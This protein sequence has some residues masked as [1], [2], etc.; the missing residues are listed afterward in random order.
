MTTLAPPPAQAPV[1]EPGISPAGRAWHRWRFWLVLALAVFVGGTAIALIGSP[2]TTSDYLDPGNPGAAGARAVATIAA[3]RGVHLVRVTTVAAAAGAAAGGQATLV[4]TSPWL[5]TTG[6]LTALSR[7]PGDRLLIEPD[8][9]S[10]T[11]LAPGVTEVG[12]APV[13][14]LDPGCGLPAATLAGSADLGGTLL[15]ASVPGAQQCYWSAGHPS[16]VRYTS[17]GRTITVLGSGAPLRNSDLASLGNAALAL[18]LLGGRP[19]IVWLVP[20][21]PP[22]AASGQKSLL[23]LI[24]LPAYLVALQLAIAAVLCALWRTRRLGPLVAERLPAVVR[25]T[26]TVEGHGQ[27]YRSRRSRDRAAAALRDAARGRL[28]PR[29]GLPDNGAPGALVTALAGQTSSTPEQVAAILFG[30]VPQDDAALVRLADELDS[31]ENA[32]GRLS[33][34]AS[35]VGRPS[36]E[37]RKVHTQ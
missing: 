19:E 17:G 3:Q 29:L 6:E 28:A 14:P 26:E 18:N 23:S 32:V 2:S 33:G 8:P 11:A 37:A 10:L 4:V 25:A 5:L 35:A 30:P 27:L 7:V 13:G 20:G 36:G 1:Q 24:P 22:L 12:A 21:P 16:L 31:L 34:Q 15:R 9:G